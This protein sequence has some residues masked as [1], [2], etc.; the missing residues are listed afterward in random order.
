MLTSTKTLKSEITARG[1][2]FVE[3]DCGAI[4]EVVYSAAEDDTCE[5]SIHTKDWSHCW[6]IDGTSVTNP[7]LDIIAVIRTVTML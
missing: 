7:E 4:Y 3:T 5:D 6:N 1:S 2:A